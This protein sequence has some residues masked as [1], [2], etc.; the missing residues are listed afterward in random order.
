MVVAQQ[1]KPAPFQ[2]FGS[3]HVEAVLLLTAQGVNLPVDERHDMVAVKDDGRAGEVFFDRTGVAGAH[4]HGHRLE[5]FGFFRHGPQK[6]RDCFLARPF[7]GMQD[8][9][10]LQIDE[11]RHVGVPLSQAKLVNAKVADPTQVDGPVACGEPGLVDILDQIPAHAEILG[12]GPDRAELQQIENGPGKRPGIAGVSFDK[13]QA[14]PPETPTSC[15]LQPMHGHL[16]Q[17][18]LAADRRH[19]EPPNILPLEMA[20]SM[21]A[22]VAGNMAV[23]SFDAE[24]EPIAEHFGAAIGDAFDAKGMIQ[25]RL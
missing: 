9:A 18:L 22:G 11:N 4:V 10:G 8:S 2:G 13:R 3:F 6:G 7:N 20:I 12:H 15:A 24:N 14:R 16:Q 19:A 23:G 17:S 5:F 1:E 21:P 25:E